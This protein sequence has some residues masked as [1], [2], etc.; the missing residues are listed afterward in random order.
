MFGLLL[1]LFLTLPSLSLAIDNTS[2]NSTTLLKHQKTY[3]LVFI[4]PKDKVQEINARTKGL[5]R[6]TLLKHNLFKEA[7]TYNIPHITVLHIHNPDPTT[8]QKMLSA[9]KSFPKPFSLHLTHFLFAP[10][11]PNA[12]YPWWF[13]IGVDKTLGYAAINA[14]NL[15]ATKAIA[16]LRATPVPRA[17]GFV[18]QD[19]SSAAKSQIQDLGTS[20]L[21][22]IKNGKKENF[23]RPHVTLIYSDSALKNDTIAAMQALQND[24]NATFTTPIKV[25][26]DSVSIVELG[27]LGNVLR[28]IYR[29]N[30]ADGKIYD[31]EKDTFITKK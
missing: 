9:L 26:F 31:V 21:N 28:E 22:R 20:G 16:P 12:V 2:L 4:L 17:T 19:S 13:D 15:E 18:Y 3:G 8:P 7:L 14:Y 25:D 27:F 1:G 10:A 6:E 29:I 30:L 11:S 5:I 24:F 23:Y